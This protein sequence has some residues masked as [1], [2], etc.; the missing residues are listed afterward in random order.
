M[1]A[2]FALALLLV[3]VCTGCAAPAG[4][5]EFERGKSAADPDEAIRA[6]EE[7]VR[8]DP[9]LAEAREELVLLYAAREEKDPEARSKVHDHL[10]ELA[11]LGR[12]LSPQ[13]REVL[14]T[15]QGGVLACLRWFTRHQAPDGRWGSGA[16]CPGKCGD[17]DLRDSE[18]IA[19]SLALLAFGGAAY[20]HWDKDKYEDVAIGECIRKGLDWLIGRQQA[21]GGFGARPVGDQA[22]ATL[23]LAQA[24][25]LTGSRFLKEP[26]Q[27]AVDFLVSRRGVD[28]GWNSLGTPE[29]PSDPA[30][31][32]W[33]LFALLSASSAEL[34]VPSGMVVESARGLLASTAGKPSLADALALSAHGSLAGKKG[35]AEVA[36]RVNRLAELPPPE[37]ARRQNAVYSLHAMIAIATLDPAEWRQPWERALSKALH[38]ARRGSSDGCMDGSWDP[39]SPADAS[40]GRVITTALNA[41][42]LE[43]RYGFAGIFC[44]PLEVPPRPVNESAPRNR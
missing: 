4:R 34:K 3:M 5:P 35:L 38:Q 26:S 27:K 39:V 28:L 29:S 30:S 6:F 11:R 13:M 20:S 37:E 31:T 15:H 42:A 19:T 1:T 25:G 10:V 18:L 40:R 44:G 7:A 24:Y 8:L 22:L 43:V 12:G 16:R 9:E 33:V 2:R 17:V 14:K 21:D 36:E 32:A 41:L 23:A